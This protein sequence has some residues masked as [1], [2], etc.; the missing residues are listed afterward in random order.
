[1]ISRTK[2]WWY[3]EEEGR[4]MVPRKEGR[5]EGRSHEGRKE[6]RKV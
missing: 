2:G 4:N 3:Q 5:M 6:G 1:M